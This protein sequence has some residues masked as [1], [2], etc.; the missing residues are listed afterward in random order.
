MLAIC[1]KEP[2]FA[3]AR[4]HSQKLSRQKR[5]KVLRYGNF[6]NPKSSGLWQSMSGASQHPQSRERKE[7]TGKALLI[8][9]MVPVVF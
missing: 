2:N 6:E 8:A 1:G 9:K 7:P 4:A 3:T 5:K